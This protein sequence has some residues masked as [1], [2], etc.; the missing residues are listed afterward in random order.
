MNEFAR[1]GLAE[2]K[3]PPVSTDDNDKVLTVDGGVWKAKTP[4]GGGGGVLVV[5]VTGDETTTLD[6]TWQE[7]HNA[8]PLVVVCSTDSEG[9]VYSY[10]V[11]AVY[12]DGV[13]YVVSTNDDYIATSSDGFPVLNGGK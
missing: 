4:S 10:F 9:G 12:L 5:N 8:M 1:P 11:R 13:N 6:K 3:L 2:E 7:I